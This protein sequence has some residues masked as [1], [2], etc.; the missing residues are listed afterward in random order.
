MPS[1]PPASL[2]AWDIVL[3]PTAETSCLDSS[4]HVVEIQ[5]REAE[6][7]KERECSFWL[8]RNCLGSPGSLTEDW[9]R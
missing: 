7:E 3:V 2:L 9:S 1:P 8:S 4:H 6:R 5:E